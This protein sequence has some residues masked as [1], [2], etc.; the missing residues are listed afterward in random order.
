VIR[1]VIVDDFPVMR[2]GLTELLE[3]VPAIQVVGSAANGSSAIA[4]INDAKPDVVL[5]DLSMPGIDGVE[6]TRRILALRADTKIVFLTA[7]S[8]PSKSGFLPLWT[9]ARLAIS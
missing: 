3:A 5:M 4:L 1:V 8:D 2:T 6:T 9:L 7:I